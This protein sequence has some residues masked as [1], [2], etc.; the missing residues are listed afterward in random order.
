MS[1]FGVAIMSLN[2]VYRHLIVEHPAQD[3]R[4]G[5]FGVADAAALMDLLP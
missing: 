3:L 2:C 5:R 4:I 1:V